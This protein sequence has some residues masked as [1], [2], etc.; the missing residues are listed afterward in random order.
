MANLADFLRECNQRFTAGT[1][2]E[3]LYASAC[4]LD[5][6]PKS[7]AELNAGGAVAAG[8]TK[9]LGEAFT[10]TTGGRWFKTRIIINT[11][12]IGKTL[13]GETGSKSIK[14]SFGFSIAGNDAETEEFNECIVASDG[15]ILFALKQRD[16]K[17]WSVLG[18]T[19]LPAFIE[20]LEGGGGAAPT[21]ANRNNWSVTAYDI[22]FVDADAQPFQMTEQA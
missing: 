6:F 13:E 8:D 15:N 5:G 18:K 10:F 1:E 2:V 4:K 3:L 9:R 22:N 19:S 21:D 20:T 7:K 11:G 17:E 14:R 16:Q 12:N